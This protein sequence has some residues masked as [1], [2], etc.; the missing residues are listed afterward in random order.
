MKKSWLIFGIS[1]VVLLSTGYWLASEPDLLSWD[2]GLQLALVAI[3][4]GFALFMG[5]RR[6]GN[7]RRGEPGEDELSVKMLRKASSWAYYQSLYLWIVIMYVSGKVET[8]TEEL[9][10]YGVMGMGILFALNYA[11]IALRGLRNE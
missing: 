5:I 11:I 6:M 3:L 4:V 2:S 10:G 1:A 7:E 8:D 9:F